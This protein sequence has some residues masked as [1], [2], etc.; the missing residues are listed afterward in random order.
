MN[1]LLLHDCLTAKILTPL[2]NDAAPHLVPPRNRS[3]FLADREKGKT[4]LLFPSLVFLSPLVDTFVDRIHQLLSLSLSLSSWTRRLFV[5]KAK[6][7]RCFIHRL[8]GRKDRSIR[9]EEEALLAISDTLPPPPHYTVCREAAWRGRENLER[10]FFWKI[11][12]GNSIG[13]GSGKV[14]AWFLG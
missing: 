12:G 14:G 4:S 3:P 11:V 5:V 10:E 8:G 1:G 13:F 9:R 2:P 7:C 6:W